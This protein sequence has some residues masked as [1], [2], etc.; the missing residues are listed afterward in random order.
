MPNTD[1]TYKITE[2]IATLSQSG[3]TSKELNLVSY[4]GAKPKYDLRRYHS[5]RRGSQRT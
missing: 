3:D 4:R 1:F 2:S 5:Q